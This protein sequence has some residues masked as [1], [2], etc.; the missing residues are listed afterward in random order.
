METPQIPVAQIVGC[1]Q[2]DIRGFVRLGFGFVRLS[3]PDE[4]AGYE[5]PEN[6]TTVV[7]LAGG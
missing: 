5:Q 4:N 2:Q 3:N 1:D 7:R 6:F